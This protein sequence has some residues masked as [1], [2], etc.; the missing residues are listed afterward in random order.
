MQVHHAAPAPQGPPQYAQFDMPQKG[1]EDSLPHM[2]SWETAGAKKVMLENNEMEMENLNKPLAQVANRPMNTPSPGPVSPMSMHHD[3]QYGM[4]PGSSSGQMS[5]HSQQGLMSNR[6]VPGRDLYANGPPGQPGGYNDVDRHSNGFGLDEPYDDMMAAAA[7]APARHFDQQP[8]LPGQQPH[9]IYGQ[10]PHPGQQLQYDP[11]QQYQQPQ[12]PSPPPQH[13]VYEAPGSFAMSNSA[14]SMQNAG[15][16]GSQARAGAVELDPHSSPPP[17]A[18]GLNSDQIHEHYAEMPAMPMDRNSVSGGA[19]AGATA[20]QKPQSATSPVDNSIPRELTG[21]TPPEGFGMR[22]APTGDGAVPPSPGRPPYGMDAQMRNSPGP[23]PRPP[24]GPQMQPPRGP[25]SPY[26]RPPR[27]SPGPGPRGPPGPGPRGYGQPPRSPRDRT[28]SP[29]P[30]RP[31]AGRP[32]PRQG[33]PAG[34]R[35][36]TAAPPRRPVPRQNDS[37]GS[38]NNAGMN[39]PSRP[40]PSSNNSYNQTPS[41]PSITNNAGFDFTSGFA[42]PQ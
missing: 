1:G 20:A 10:S 31:G 40:H 6:Q 28:Y 3:R 24:P 9:D 38:A 12:Q 34:E 2:P 18:Q 22:R 7:V 27:G 39:P 33:P 23:G 21:S 41:P 19:G 14:N 42:R 13:P 4:L 8:T 29:A 35:L 36:Y 32:P 15:Y 37:Y 30:E 25:D 16:G 26:G 11:Y 5:N 17:A